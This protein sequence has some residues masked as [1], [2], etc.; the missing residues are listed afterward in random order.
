M[1]RVL[2]RL[3]GRSD[4]IIVENASLDDTPVLAEIHEES[5]QRGWSDGDFHNQ[6]SNKAYFCLMARIK[7]AGNSAPSAFMLVRQ[8]ADEA[9]LITIATRKSARR[10]GLARHLID[11]AIRKLQA[12]RVTN[13]FLDVD[14]NNHAARALYETLGFTKVGERAAY[15]SHSLDN[16][17]KRSRALVMRLELS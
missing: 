15:Y 12:D 8:V 3:L 17:E 5:F 10:Q 14:E 4:T 9:E 11:A 1:F 13:V 6:L 2:S 16:G 7:G